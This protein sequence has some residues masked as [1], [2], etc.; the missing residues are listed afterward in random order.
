MKF[1]IQKSEL[2]VKKGPF[3]IEITER[4]PFYINTAQDIEFYYTVARFKEY[5]LLTLDVSANLN[6]TC[7]RCLQDFNYRYL[8]TNN[9]AVCKSDEIAEKIMSTYEPLVSLTNEVDLLE[10]ITDDLH[11][12]CPEV[13]ENCN[14]LT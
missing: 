8:N 6:I 12:Y 2:M 7:Q 11:L 1:S 5:Y 14:L 9:I 10:I 13:H 4:L 3:S